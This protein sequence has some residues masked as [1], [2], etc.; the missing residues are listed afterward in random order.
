MRTT[1]ELKTLTEDYRSI[2]EDANIDFAQLK[3]ARI[4]V[5]GAT[6]FVGSLMIRALLFAD[7]ELDLGL[8]IIGLARNRAKIEPIY[9]KNLPPRLT[10][11]FG[12]ITAP[13]E[14]YISGFDRID[15]IF[16]TANV[17]TSAYMVSNPVDTIRIAVMGTDQML[18][19]AQD[20]HVKSLVYLSSMEMYGVFDEREA[21]TTI[22]TEKELGYV[23]LQVVRNCY[24]ESKRMCE[25]LCAAY[26]SQHGV[27]VKIA[28]L[29]QTF[30]AGLLPW[31]GRI[32]SHIA[33]CVIK[34][35]DIVLHTK[36]LSEGN[37]CYSSDMIRGLLT[38]LLKGEDAEAYNVVNERNHS[39]IVGM[40][41]MVCHEVAEDRIKVVYDIPEHN[42]FGY[43]QDTRLKLSGEKLQ[44]LGWRP[45][46]DL[47]QMYIRT[48]ASLSEK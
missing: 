43:A 4:L 30:G 28:R 42:R 33:D 6:G 14:Q 29:A 17:T 38:I 41:K 35:E 40:V 13:Y 21:A 39:T 23:D 10:F 32:F 19:M 25:S 15:Y 9:G 37:Y 2:L 5:S 1:D 12:D 34:G 20:L 22:R 24:P 44:S 7:Q 48:I 36:G 47:K 8:E 45:K 11:L 46:Y 16:H 3:Q 26:H 27:P 31:E 18:R